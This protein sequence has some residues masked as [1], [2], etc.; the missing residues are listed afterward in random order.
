MSIT[1]TWLSPDVSDSEITHNMPGYSILRADRINRQGGG[2]A[3]FVKD[4]LTAEVL[5]TFN[6]DVCQMI[7]VNILQINTVIAMVYRLPNIEYLSSVH[8]YNV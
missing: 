2:V 7:I 8:C 6:N 1:E 4:E 5:T 3:L